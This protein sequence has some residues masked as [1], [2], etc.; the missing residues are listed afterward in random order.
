MKLN[1]EQLYKLYILENKSRDEVCSILSISSTTFKR[2]A[3]K[4]N[5]K[6]PKKLIVQVREKTCLEKYNVTNTSKLQI[7]K[8]KITKTN[9]LK[10][11]KINYAQT[12]ECKA[13]M[14]ETCLKKYNGQGNESKI[15]KEKHKQ[16]M[17]KKYGVDS[18]WKSKNPK[19]RGGLITEQAL[20]KQYLTKK[21]NKSFNSSKDEN[22]IYELLNKKFIYVYREYKS[23]E[24]PFYCDFYIKDLDLYIEYN[25]HA[26]HGKDPYDITNPKHQQILAIWK[27]KAQKS[28]YY[29][30]MI[31]IWTI[32][33]P[34]K[35]EFANKNS[36]NYLKFYTLN[37]FI[38]WYN[39]LN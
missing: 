6:K 9:L 19:I 24:Y 22:I 15:L 3:K 33:D 23:K 32:K 18:N 14:R 10:Y 31:R 34:Q 12:F 16:T 39:K 20:Y 17:L 29:Q 8:D 2:Y 25:G 21:K 11:G 37:E 36:L 38:E 7:V 30:A 5:I 27:E 26:T 35:Q 1:K 13:K 28:K 4:Y